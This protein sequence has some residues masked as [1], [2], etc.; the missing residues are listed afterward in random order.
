MNIYFF[1]ILLQN[2]YYQSL[3]KDGIGLA[4]A[5]LCAKRGAKLI[6]LCRFVRFFGSPF[7][8]FRNNKKMQNARN[9]ILSN[10]PDAH[11]DTVQ[12]DLADLGADCF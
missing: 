1:L 5:I 7:I 10:F 9:D 12:M 8:I 11:V 4:T 2:K 6:L 3:L